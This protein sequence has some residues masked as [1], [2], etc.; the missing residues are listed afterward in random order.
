[1]SNPC[2]DRSAAR[3]DGDDLWQKIA[4]LLLPCPSGCRVA[5]TSRQPVVEARLDDHIV[6]TRSGR[7][8]FR[9][10]TIARAARDSSA[11]DR[12][13][14][15]VG[16]LSPADLFPD[17]GRRNSDPDRCGAGPVAPQ[18]WAISR[19]PALADR[20]HRP[21]PHRLVGVVAGVDAFCGDG[22]RGLL[23]NVGDRP[24][25]RLRRGLPAGSHQDLESL[26]PADRHRRSGAGDLHRRP[27]RPAEPA[28]RRYR[29]I[30]ARSRGGEP[31][32][33]RLAV[34]RRAR[35]A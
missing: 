2:A 32:R 1:M 30:D 29:R 24:S 12:R 25:R 20:S 18:P 7:S 21:F 28:R 16:R 34:A 3:N 17:A 31:H 13:A 5:W 35:R 26:P 23:Q 11:C 14:L 10:C 33:H 27:R 6:A 22:D 8:F 19:G 9:C 4:H 15:R